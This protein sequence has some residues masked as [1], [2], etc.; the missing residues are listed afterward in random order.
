MEQEREGQPLRER[1]EQTLV[2]LD[3]EELLRLRGDLNTAVN[4]LTV[5]MNEI[6]NTIQAYNNEY[7]A[8]MLA[9]VLGQDEQRF[10]NPLVDEQVGPEIVE[11]FRAVDE[12][13][14]KHK[15]HLDAII[16][17]ASRHEQSYTKQALVK[18]T[19]VP[20][21][22]GRARGVEGYR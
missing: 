17:K 10:C 14:R 5:R 19:E 12:A 2:R 21:S 1:E 6:V 16:M 4:A 13:E 22:F 11:L 15:S 18:R 3:D 9:Y 7:D 20:A 8:N